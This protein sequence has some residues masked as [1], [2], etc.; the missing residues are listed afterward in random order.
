MSAIYNDSDYFMKLIGLILKYIL[1]F[2]WRLSQAYSVSESRE[3]VFSHYQGV[4][5]LDTRHHLTSHST[6]MYTFK[7]KYHI[8]MYTYKQKTKT[9]LNIKIEF[10]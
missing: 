10:L 9:K 5:V 1:K 6:D 8:C 7:R 3:T 2:L 4:V